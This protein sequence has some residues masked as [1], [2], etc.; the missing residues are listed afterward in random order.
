MYRAIMI[1]IITS[2]LSEPIQS[3]NRGKSSL[4]YEKEK[5]QTTT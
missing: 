5:K 4:K 2:F 3:E 1:R